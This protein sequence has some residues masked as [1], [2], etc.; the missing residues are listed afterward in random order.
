MGSRA[1][2]GLAFETSPIVTKRK[3]EV[4]KVAGLEELGVWSCGGKMRKFLCNIFSFPK[5]I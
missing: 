1:Q 4:T 5:E 2:E 3:E